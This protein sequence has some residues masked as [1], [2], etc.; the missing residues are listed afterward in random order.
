[1]FQEADPRL[2][3]REVSAALAEGPV[4]WTVACLG[5]RG[6]LVAVPLGSRQ[7]AV[8]GRELKTMQNAMYG[9]LIARSL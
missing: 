2:G 6:P 4:T 8:V 9:F 5:E 3:H 1:M 7:C